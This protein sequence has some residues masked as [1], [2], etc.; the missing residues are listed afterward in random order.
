MNNTQAT[1]SGTFT[2]TDAKL[3]EIHERIAYLFPAHITIT[4]EQLRIWLFRYEE[5]VVLD[6]LARTAVKFQKVNG[7]MSS[8]YVGKYASMVMRQYHEKRQK[9]TEAA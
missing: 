2:P 4:D 7:E 6:A 5:A 3:K 8:D 1:T 9:Q